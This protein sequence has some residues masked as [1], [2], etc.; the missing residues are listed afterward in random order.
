[1]YV[2]WSIYVIVKLF[3]KVLIRYKE[4]ALVYQFFASVKIDLR[5]FNH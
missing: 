3:V 2:F 4:V 5:K 1:M